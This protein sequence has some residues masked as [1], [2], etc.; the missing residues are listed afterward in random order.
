MSLCSYLVWR[1]YKGTLSKDPPLKYL[2]AYVNLSHFLRYTVQPIPEGYLWDAKSIQLMQW[3]CFIIARLRRRIMHMGFFVGNQGVEVLP[4]K[5][6]KPEVVVSMS[7]FGLRWLE[8]PLACC[9][10]SPHQH[11]PRP[12]PPNPLPP[13]T[14]AHS[15]R[16]HTTPKPRGELVSK[17]TAEVRF[18]TRLV[19]SS[20]QRPSQ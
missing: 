8:V 5:G 16:Y 9:F 3:I 19:A 2:K 15:A 18:L 17:E 14:T 12:H 20:S 7:S 11:R 1:W 6:K 13:A 10:R 4:P